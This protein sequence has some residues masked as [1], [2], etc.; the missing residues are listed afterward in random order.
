MTVTAAVLLLLL[1]PQAMYCSAACRA[2]DAAGPHRPGGPECGVPWPRLLPE[3]AL[4]ALRA[5]VAV[6]CCEELR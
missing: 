6:S 4:V 1:M 3:E 5:C 2:A